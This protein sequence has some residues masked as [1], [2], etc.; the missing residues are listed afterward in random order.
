MRMHAV[1]T[2]PSWSCTGSASNGL[3]VSETLGRRVRVRG[4]AAESKRQVV[5]V[6]LGSGASLEAAE[7]DICD[8]L[9][10]EDVAAYHGRF[11]GRR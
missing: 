3:V 1:G 6:A 4:F 10:G 5:A 8:S 7:D 11:V 9:T 2:I